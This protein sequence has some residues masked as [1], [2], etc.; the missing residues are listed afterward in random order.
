MDTIEGNYIKKFDAVV[1]KS[2]KDYVCLDRTAFYPLGGGQPADTGVLQ[3]NKK[4]SEVTTVLKKGMTIEHVLLGEKPAVGTFVHGS[5]DW[6]KRYQHMKM[7]TAQ[8]ILSGVVFEEF[9][10]RTV[11]NQIYAD[12]SRVDFQPVHFTDSEVVQIEKKCNEIITKNVPIH[13]HK[14]QR[15]SFEQMIDRNR[16]DLDL[17]PKTITDLR[18]VEIEGFDLC[19]CAGTHVRNT[20]ELPSFHILKKENKGKQKERLIYTLTCNSKR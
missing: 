19:P 13:I 10:A 2:K 7:H 16:C 11:G 18:I 20:S 9:N 15:E 12:H 3:W 14:K 8:H 4:Q 5:I 17:L 1:T 6:K